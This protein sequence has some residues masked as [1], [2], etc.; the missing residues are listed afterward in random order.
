MTLDPDSLLGQP[1]GRYILDRLLGQ[2][3]FAW[4]FAAHADDGAP[5]ALKVLK[6]RY[7]GDPQFATR[8][9]NEGQVASKLDHPNILRPLEI[10]Q[11]GQFTF[12]VMRLYPQS[13]R[14]AIEEGGPLSED[15][16]VRLAREL[17]AGLA[18]AHE[19]GFIHRDIKPDNVLVAEDGTFLISDFGIARA[20]SGYSSATGVNMTIGTPQYI[21]PEQAQGRTLDGRSD[22]YALGVTLYKATTG[23]VPFRSTDWFELAR[24]HVEEQPT[25]PRKKRPNLSK[26][27]EQVI[28]KCLA[29]HPDDRYASAQALEDELEELASA[30]RRTESFGIPPIDTGELRAALAGDGR[31]PRWVLGLVA[32]VVVIVVAVVVVLLGR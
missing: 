1:I 12:F 10:G 5:V 2:G 6:P 20:V 11:E 23:D 4:V 16:A 7:A 19:A 26:R 25:P 18:Y 27:L 22:L 30:D 17:A 9:R 15:D 21:S 14:T 24:M 28:L 8:F 13:L 29:K 32:L 3:G 31:R